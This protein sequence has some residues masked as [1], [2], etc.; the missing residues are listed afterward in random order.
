VIEL[1]SPTD[2]LKATQ[3]KMKEYIDHKEYIDNAVLLGLL[4]NRKSRQVAIYI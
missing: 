3:E 2:R 1:L 4:V